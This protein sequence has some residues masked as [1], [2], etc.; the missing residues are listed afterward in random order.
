MGE[1]YVRSEFKVKAKIGGYVFEDVVAISATFGLNSIPNASLQVASGTCVQDGKIATI[2]EALGNIRNREKAIVTLTVITNDGQTNKMMEDGEYVIFEG[3]YSGMGY[4]RSNTNA[5]Y[6]IHLLHWIDDLNCSSMLNGNWFQ[7]VPHDLAQGASNYSVGTGGTGIGQVNFTPLI[8]LQPKLFQK[9]NLTDDMW[10]LSIKPMFQAIANM[11]HVTIQEGVDKLDTADD[12]GEGGATNRA[13]LRALARMPGGPNPASLPLAVDDVNNVVIHYSVQTGITHLITNA[14]GYSS[15]WSK[16]VGELGAAF[17][18]GI[19]PSAEFANVIPY[20]GG[21]RRYWKE[22][23][24]DEYN[25]ASFNCNSANLIESV[26]IFYAQQSLAGNTVGSRPAGAPISYFFPW[27]V[28]PPFGDRDLRGQILVR[29]PP[30]WIANPAPQAPCTPRT[31][32]TEVGDAW[33][34]QVG[35]PDLPSGVLSASDAEKNVKQSSILNRFAEHW[36]KSTI[37]GQ[38]AGE[39]SGKLR[40]DIAPG[41]TIKINPPSTAI[42]ATEESMFATVTQVSFVINAEQHVAGTSFSLIN[43]RNRR[44]QTDNKLTNVSPPLYKKGWPGGPL[45]VKK[46]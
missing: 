45:A 16:L 5:T 6:T 2:H 37:L 23:K 12:A 22:I 1:P 19:S 20:F 24:A 25:Y 39:L 41:S 13:A 3:Y 31:T 32:L 38:R 44:E 34:P 4:Q 33:E 26:N 11:Q 28:Y 9:G 8:E 36:Y 42:G 18:F 15:F 43:I 30:S 17:L 14:M 7:G 46:S 27:G 10:K 35:P 29:D 21:L 40:F